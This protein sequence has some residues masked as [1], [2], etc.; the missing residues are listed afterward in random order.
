MNAFG[1]AQ[2]PFC[3]ILDFEGEEAVVCTPE[4]LAEKGIQLHINGFSNDDVAGHNGAAPP[5]HIEPVPYTEY[6]RAFHIVQGHLQAGNSYLVNLTFPTRIETPFRLED[7]YRA[8]RAPYKLLWPGRFVVFSPEQFVR[9]RSGVISTY[10][11]KGTIDA[12]LP[13][14]AEFI[15]AD[16]KEH[17]EHVTIVDLL[18]NDLNRVARQVRV[19]R[20]RYIDRIYTNKKDLLQVSSE[21]TGVLPPDYSSHLGD[22]FAELL[23]AGSISGAPKYKTLEIIRE[24]EGAPRGFYTGVFGYFN[25]RNLESAVMIRFIEQQPNGMCFRSGGGITILSDPEQEYRELIDKV[26]LPM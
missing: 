11:M 13:D 7:I 5:L 26:Y 3:F 6:L 15:L 22:I 8:G 12:D 2:Q 17:A 14:A 16:V 24:A 1:A 19:T 20:F 18:R 10:P 23:P 4:E 25:G 21:I 9:I